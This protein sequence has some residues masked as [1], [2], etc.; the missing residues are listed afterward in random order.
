MSSSLQTGGLQH[1]RLP[2]PLISSGV[3]SDSWSLSSW[4]HLSHSLSPPS[5][6]P[7]LRA[8]HPLN[9]G[10]RAWASSFKESHCHMLT[11]TVPSTSQF[12]AFHSMRLWW[13][14][15][16]VAQSCATLCDPV[17]YTIHEILQD[18]IL[19]CITVLFS[20][21][22][23]QARDRTQDSCIAGRHFTSWATSLWYLRIWL[24][25]K[26]PG[27]FSSCWLGNQTLRLLFIPCG[28]F[29]LT[30][31][32]PMNCSPP[33]SSVHWFFPSKNTGVGCCFLLLGIFPTQRSNPHL[34]HCRWILYRWAI[35]E[36]PVY[37]MVSSTD[38]LECSY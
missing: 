20:R 7:P 22:Y 32:D 4:C 21:G 36:A 2:C 27:P 33:A 24:Y 1:A 23:S 35:W 3:C 18:R 26:F 8:W 14:E 25:N 10:W 15:V 11:A 9:C 37:I 30:P 34:L 17:D 19:G 5:P 12:S 6:R 29:C 38:Y 31:C 16:K 13:S 28:Q